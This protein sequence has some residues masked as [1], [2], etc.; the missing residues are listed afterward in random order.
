[1]GVIKR[2]VIYVSQS[3]IWIYQVLVVLF[4]IFFLKCSVKLMEQDVLLLQ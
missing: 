3:N 4:P 2:I 1:M